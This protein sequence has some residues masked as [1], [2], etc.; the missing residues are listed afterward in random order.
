MPGKILADIHGHPMLWHVFQQIKKCEL[1]A[2][3]LVV[4]DSDEIAR[5]VTSW[6]GRAIMSSPDCTCGTER[7]ASICDQLDAEIVVN[8]QG[9]EP[10]IDPAL[11]DNLITNCRASDADMV[12]PVVKIESTAIL[13]SNTTVKVV[14]RHD[15]TALYFSR[16]PVPYIRDAV[17]ADWTKTTDFWLQ[18]GTYAFRREVLLEYMTWPEGTLE[19]LE[20]VEQLRFLEAGKKILTFETKHHSMAVDTPDD[21]AKIREIMAGK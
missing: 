3:I 14:V 12:T 7:I 9:D 6:G 21:L 8:V 15:G 20:K 5:Q 10:L 4:T 1:P 13:E 11:I 19:M 2:D 18:V 16:S 17:P